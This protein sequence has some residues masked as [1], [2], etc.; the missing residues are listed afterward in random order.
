MLSVFLDPKTFDFEPMKFVVLRKLLSLPE[1]VINFV[2]RDDSG[3]ATKPLP[4][5]NVD[6]KKRF[7]NLERKATLDFVR[8]TSHTALVEHFEENLYDSVSNSEI[9]ED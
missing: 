2:E 4:T 1:R 6:P 9:A 8:P 5:S 3:V 7:N